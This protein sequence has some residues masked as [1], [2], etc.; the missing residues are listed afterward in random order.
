MK[1]LQD[2]HKM[3][4]IMITHDLGVVAELADD[5]IVMYGGK[6]VEQAHGQ[7]PLRE[8]EHPYTWGLLRLAAAPELDRRAASSRF[9]AS[10]RRC[11]TRRRAARSTR[12]ASTSMDVCRTDLPELRHSV[13][14]RRAPSAA[15]STTRP[16]AR[17][18]SAKRAGDREDAADVADR[19]RE[20]DQ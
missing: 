18:W 14:G 20:R 19:R 1:Q 12:A 13:A 9:P 7:R 15:T 3:A 4:I 6:V 2:E 10:R 17:I 8:A 11:S 16:R 5:V